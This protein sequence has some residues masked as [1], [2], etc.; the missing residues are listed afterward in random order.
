MEPL[1]VFFSA[2]FAKIGS[3]TNTQKDWVSNARRTERQAPDVLPYVRGTQKKEVKIP[4]V[5]V[6]F[7]CVFESI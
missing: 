4:A 1:I 3:E 6:I 2:N 7:T 5:A